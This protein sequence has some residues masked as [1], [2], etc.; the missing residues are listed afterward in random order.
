[1][2]VV[3]VLIQVLSHARVI[4]H[5]PM[6]LNVVFA[7]KVFQGRALTI[8]HEIVWATSHLLLL[9]RLVRLSCSISRKITIPDD[10]RK[11]NHSQFRT[12]LSKVSIQLL[13]NLGPVVS[14]VLDI[15]LNL[16]VFLVLQQKA[17]IWPH[18]SISLGHVGLSVHISTVELTTEP[19]N[20]SLQTFLR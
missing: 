3:E 10:V 5:I 14:V 6:G 2:C 4:H 8:R 12:E 19:K 7:V 17:R 13:K 11:R 9:V 16:R 20:N 1:V 15:E 18:I